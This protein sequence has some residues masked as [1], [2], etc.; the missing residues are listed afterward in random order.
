MF[1]EL[2]A[3]V[4]ELPKKERPSHD[5]I[6][7]G[8]WAFIDERA[9]RRKHGTLTR[10]E[11][12]RIKRRINKALAADRLERALQAGHAIMAHLE[13]GKLREAWGVARA[14]HKEVDPAASPPCYL[15]L[16]KQT[17]EREELYRKRV[18]PGERIPSN[19]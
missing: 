9:S 1:E 17:V 15:E 11:G 12:R 2:V 5:W 3:A 16:E 7:P 14:W 13:A 19:A 6:R 10:S 4:E 8:T 18:P